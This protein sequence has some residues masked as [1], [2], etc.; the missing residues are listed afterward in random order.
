MVGPNG[1]PLT[2][3]ILLNGKAGEAISVAWQRTLAN[4]GINVTVRSVDSAQYLQ[5]QRV[6]DFDAMLMTYISTLSPG[7]EQIGRW[8]S[9]SK[10]ADGTYNYAGVADPAV[11]AM[12]ENLLTVRSQDDFRGG[13][14]G[15]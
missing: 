9:Q 10:D 5:R 8:G 13:G 1:K 2:F 15:L 6:Y 12:I 3:E 14:A 11:D 7:T 4:L